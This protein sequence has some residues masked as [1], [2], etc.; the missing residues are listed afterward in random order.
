MAEEGVSVQ[1]ALAR[2]ELYR[3]QID[4]LNR[5]LALVQSVWTETA[6]ARVTLEDW[7]SLKTGAPVLVPIG[8][9]TF[10]HAS[11]AEPDKTLLGVGAGYSLER[12]TTEAVEHLTT[13]EKELAAEADRLSAA[14]FEMQQEAAALE[15]A[16]ESS[17][18]ATP[19]GRSARTAS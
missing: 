17:L 16:I 2:L 5:S 3:R 15:E 9:N 6:R 8:G 4:S 10:L 12:S 14:A 13:R 11:A 19:Q 18:E 7:K 1:D